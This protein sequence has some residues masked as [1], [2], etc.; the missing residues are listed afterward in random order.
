MNK[1]LIIDRLLTD[2]ITYGKQASV[3]HLLVLQTWSKTLRNED[4][5]PDDWLREPEVLVGMEPKRSRRSPSPMPERRG[6][7]R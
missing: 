6:R 4:E 2:K 1:R 3:P 5:I 7:N